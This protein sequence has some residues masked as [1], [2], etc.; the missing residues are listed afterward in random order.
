MAV[1]IAICDDNAE[2]VSQL[3]AALYAYDP[4]FEITSFP[5]G[6]ALMDELLDGSLNADLLFLDIYI[7]GIDG[8]QTARQIRSVWSDIKIIF[9]SSSRDHYPQAYEVFAFN[10]IVKPFSRERLYAV[11][12]RALDELC[13][14]SGYKISVRHK[15]KLH[16]VDCRDILY[17]ESR[18]KLLLFHLAGDSILQCYGK[19]ED[20][21]KEL[22]EQYFL[23]CH[24]SFIVNLSHIS[25]MG[26]SYFRIGKTMIGISR[27]YG[28]E[29]KDRYYA[30][31]FSQMGGEQTP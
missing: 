26:N 21:L 27:R 22:P 20:I 14:E 2:D 6:K 23:R 15:G 11:L 5:D 9:L 29:A 3:S 13:K 18:D 8:I 10:Y 12:S 28:K 17:I 25:E 30:Y 19:L 31:L 4:L 16:S 1:K 7:P 24:Q